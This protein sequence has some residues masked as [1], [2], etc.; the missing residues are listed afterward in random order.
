VDRYYV[1]PLRR[2]IYR[3]LAT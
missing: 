1:L 2:R 3:I